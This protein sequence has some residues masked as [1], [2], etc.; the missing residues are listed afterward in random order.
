MILVTGGTGF[1][2]Q[3]LIRH[4]VDDGR[5]VRTLLRPSKKTPELPR[6]VRVE[7]AISSI[8]DERSLRAAVSGVETIFHLVGVEWQG[9]RGDLVQ[10][11]I[12]GT[13]TLLRVAEEAGVKRIVY[14][15]HL[16]ANRASAY[17]VI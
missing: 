12:E 7:V 13:K 4:L 9:V 3:A 17:T 5:E 15:S 10:V 6:Q 16:G 14:L 8:F 11:E 2:E 1:I